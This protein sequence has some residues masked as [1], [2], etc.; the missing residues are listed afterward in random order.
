M[1]SLAENIKYSRGSEWKRWDLHIHTPSSI[2]VNP[3]SEFNTKLINTLKNNNIVAAAI[4]DHNVI[5]VIKIKDLKHSAGDD[6]TIFPGVEINLCEG[7]TN[8]HWTIIFPENEIDNPNDDTREYLER[9]S[10]DLATIMGDENKST[11]H[12]LNNKFRCIKTIQI[13]DDYAKKYHGIVIIHAGKKE[14]GLKQLENQEHILTNYLK[15]ADALEIEDY[16]DKNDNSIKKYQKPCL[17]CSDN[18]NIN[19]YAPKGLLWIKSNPTFEG[20][21]QALCH[22]E[23][24]I[25]LDDEPKKFNI[26]RSNLRKYIDSV[27]IEK[28]SN[29][30]DHHWFDIKDLKISNAL[31][32]IIGNKGSG[33]SALADIIALACSCES[34]KNGEGS[35][36]N[37]EKFM[38][39]YKVNTSYA[40]EYKVILKLMDSAT[41]L[42]EKRFL[43]YDKVTFEKNL[44]YYLPQKKIDNICSDIDLDKHF[45]KEI[46]S[47]IFS[48]VDT[49]EKSI[50]K[51]LDE[52]IKEKTK[53]PE[54]DIL[55]LKTK[56]KEQNNIIINLEEDRTENTTLKLQN[57]LRDKQDALKNHIDNKPEQVN[58]PT[59]KLTSEEEKNYKA[60]NTKIVELETLISEKNNLI[61]QSNSEISILKDCKIEIKTIKES[62]DV[63]NKKIQNNIIE[64]KIKLSQPTIEAKLTPEIE[65]IIDNRITELEAFLSNTNKELGESIEEN[66]DDSIEEKEIPAIDEKIILTFTLNYQ[67]SIYKRKKESFT[68]K[69]QSEAK[70]Y[71]QYRENLKIWEE[72]KQKF[73]GSINDALKKHDRVTKKG[74]DGKSLLDMEYE[75]ALTN[76][77]NIIIDIFKQKLLIKKEYQKIIGL[78]K[79]KLYNTLRKQKI[80]ISF[81]E[82]LTVKNLNSK[83]SLESKISDSYD[84]RIL[85]T[86][87]TA[88]SVYE[89]TKKIFKE[90]NQSLK[91]KDDTVKINSVLSTIKDFHSYIKDNKDKNILKTEKKDFYELLTSLD[92]ITT[93]YQIKLEERPLQF[94]SSGEKCI[95]LLVF[96]LALSKDDIPLI[97]DQPEDNLDNNSIFE[98]LAPCIRDAKERRQIIIVTHNPNIATACDAEQ[99]I[100]ATIN[101]KENK[102]TYDSGGI[103]NKLIKQ[104]IVDVLEGTEPAFYLRKNKY[105][106]K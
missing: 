4:T 49:V 5:D 105:N 11:I 26:V 95:V 91:D 76:R 82:E 48:Y 67:L 68:S 37:K 10:G 33:K 50:Y 15:V 71:E 96:Y 66:H 60:I 9:L 104:A 56:L 25:C 23:Q 81:E 41:D 90:L 40:D 53:E 6:I 85:K 80:N 47:V 14:P 92:Y 78:I 63:F 84:Q 20:L 99:V 100:Y 101:K 44:A 29:A 97:I 79:N 103:E 93:K 38:A 61:M 36:I 87:P 8:I 102:I 77:D 62:I 98:K 34:I 52:Y 13:A 86:F 69:M 32:V 2:D 46:D 94:L 45:N 24:R 58:E 18:H 12:P 51:N 17:I 30:D 43:N 27:S 1:P 55:S 74:D 42:H 28:T 19:D 7:T 3:E 21:R 88:N 59:Q 39:N 35:F 65:K 83:E 73:E 16:N 75:T 54:N 89:G 106:F 64:E 22:Y 72:T 70:K 57:D 31:T